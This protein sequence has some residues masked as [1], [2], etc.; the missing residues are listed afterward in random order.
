MA[1]QKSATAKARILIESITFPDPA[2][3]RKDLT[4]DSPMV[5]G[6]KGEERLMP[7]WFAEDRAR[8]KEV[9]ILE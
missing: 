8:H 5:T 2:T 1:E 3:D 9:E 6:V 7:R 4:K